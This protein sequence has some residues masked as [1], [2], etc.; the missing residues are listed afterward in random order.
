MHDSAQP[1][2]T[3][4]HLL[5]MLVKASFDGQAVQMRLLAPTIQK[6]RHAP[7]LSA[8]ASTHQDIVVHQSVQMGK[9]YLVLGHQAVK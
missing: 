3:R 7:P 8:A 6:L 2:S 5:P 1:P 9:L 4:A